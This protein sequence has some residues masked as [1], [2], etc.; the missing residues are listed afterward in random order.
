[1]NRAGF[2]ILFA[3]LFNNDVQAGELK[4]LWQESRAAHYQ[5]AATQELARAEEL[6]MDMFAGQGTNPEVTARWR[7]LGFTTTSVTEGKRRFVVVREAATRRDGRGFFV[8]REHPRRDDALQAPHAYADL[9]TGTIALKLMRSGRFLGLAMNTVPR[10]YEV[11]GKTFGADMAHLEGTY[12]IAFSHAYARSKPS[13]RLFQLHGFSAKKRSEGPTSQA[14]LIISSGT[15]RSSSHVQRIVSCLRDLVGDKAKLYPRD[16]RELG[17]TYNRIGSKLRALGHNG[18]VH[19]EMEY[20]F[21]RALSKDRALRG[22]F[23]DCLQSA[24]H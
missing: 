12:M 9:Y 2:A 4:S 21:R 5:P 18:F 15:K 22:R 7:A 20:E 24:A 19:I 23:L 10:R 6:F 11:D 1:M 16:V 8:F 14:Q 17:G 13:G 3:I